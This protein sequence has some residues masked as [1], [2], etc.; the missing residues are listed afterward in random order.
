MFSAKLV[1]FACLI[2]SLHAAESLTQIQTLE[3]DPRF[4]N[5]VA[6]MV[7]YGS[8]LAELFTTKF[9]AMTLAVIL[10]AMI[11]DEAATACVDFFAGVFGKPSINDLLEMSRISID[12][13][14]TLLYFLF[15]GSL[16]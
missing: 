5:C 4:V 6:L 7:Q 3:Q 2:A 13:F 11:G 9:D 15:T 16:Y 10:S 1:L 12:E 14:I 8:Q